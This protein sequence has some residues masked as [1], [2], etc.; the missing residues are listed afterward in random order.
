MDAKQVLSDA[1]DYVNGI[2]PSVITLA[3][4]AKVEPIEFG[5]ALFD[6]EANGDYMAGLLLAVRKEIVKKVKTAGQV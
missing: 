2:T 3:R 4:L 5:K 6:P 1:T